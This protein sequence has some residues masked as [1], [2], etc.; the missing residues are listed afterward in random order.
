[1]P[2]NEA[3]LNLLG[4]LERLS[5]VLIKADADGGNPFTSDSD[6][7]SLGASNIGKSDFGVMESVFSLESN[8]INNATAKIYQSN[9]C[10]QIVRVLFQ[11]NDNIFLKYNVESFELIESQEYNFNMANSKLIALLRMSTTTW[12][13]S[14]VE[15][16]SRKEDIQ[17]NIRIQVDASRRVTVYLRCKPM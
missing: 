12:D 4:I 2:G 11:V 9:T 10:D 14:S 3:G 17:L 1:M 6:L 16:S 15:N 13:V 5:D 8:T 7:I